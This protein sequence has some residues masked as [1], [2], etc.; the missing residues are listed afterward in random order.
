MRRVDASN[1]SVRVFGTELRNPLILASGVVSGTKGSL[2][3][4]A[5]NGANIALILG[6]KEAIDD[7]IIVRDMQSGI[8]E[9]IPL[10]KLLG[11]LKKRFKEQAA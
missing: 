9:T 1:L 8:Q 10:H 4:A 11:E 5:K 7:N 3:T 2:E 6:Q